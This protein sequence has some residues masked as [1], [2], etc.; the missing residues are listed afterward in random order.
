M[1]D[2]F[3]PKTNKDI[4]NQRLNNISQ[5]NTTEKVEKTSKAAQTKRMSVQGTTATDIGQTIGGFLS[6]T[7]NT[8]QNQTV[9]DEPVI[10]IVT[11]SVPGVTTTKVSSSKGDI[12]TLTGTST[13]DGQLDKL[14]VTA[15][16]AGI[17]AALQDAFSL[18]DRQTRQ[19]IQ[20]TSP[21]P[22]VVEEAS[23]ENISKTVTVDAQQVVK[24]A[25]RILGNPLGSSNPFGSLG[26]PFGNILGSILGKIKGSGS[27]KNFGDI[28][29]GVPP[30][31]VVPEGVDTPVDI[32]DAQGNTTISQSTEPAQNASKDIK[33]SDTPYVLASNVSGWRGAATPVIT[34]GGDYEFKTVHTNEELEAELR[35]TVRNLTTAVTHWS[36]THSDSPLNAYHIHLLHIAAQT[37]ALGGDLKLLFDQGDVNGI[38]WHYCILKDGTIQRGRPID[39]KSPESVGFSDNAVHIGF[40]AGYTA[41][42][43]TPNSELT[44]SPASI[45]PEQWKSFDKFLESFY[46]AYPGGEVLSHKEIDPNSTCPG[47]DVTSYVSGKFNRTSVYTDAKERTDA[48]TP[49]E[50]VNRKPT[51][52]RESSSSTIESAPDAQALV[53]ADNDTTITEDNLNKKALEYDKLERKLLSSQRELNGLKKELAQKSNSGNTATLISRIEKLENDVDARRIAVNK[54]RQDL[55]NNGYTYNGSLWSK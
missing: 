55:M 45:T 16:P 9:T 14:I 12:A 22:D 25:N 42:F 1:A 49:E 46:K 28:L 44:L 33:P 13:A 2:T 34:G 15:N 18:T 41:A 50:M 43:G 53:D 47:F 27:V 10:S 21:A 3:N 20:A 4:F 7:K 8:K 19:A 30:G 29:P 48:L 26:N 51:T 5:T 6:L 38:E 32:I 23:K 35:S 54:S 52:I 36:R 39:I 17:K 37:E 24:K 11:E 31:F 40:V